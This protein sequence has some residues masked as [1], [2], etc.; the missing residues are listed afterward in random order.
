LDRRCPKFAEVL[1][2]ENCKNEVVLIPAQAEFFNRPPDLMSSKAQYCMQ[3]NRID[4]D[5]L[6]VVRFNFLVT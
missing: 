4:S 2:N 6:I 3:K 5:G 1:E